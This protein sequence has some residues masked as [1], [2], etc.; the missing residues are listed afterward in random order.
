MLALP[1]SEQLKL[2]RRK[3]LHLLVRSV[4]ATAKDDSLNT[5]GFSTPFQKASYQSASKSWL[6]VPDTA[7]LTASV[8]EFL[9]K[10]KKKKNELLWVFVIYTTTAG[11]SIF[12]FHLTATDR[13]IMFST[14]TFGNNTHCTDMLQLRLE[15]VYN[16]YQ[17]ATREW[18]RLYMCQLTFLSQ[19]DRFLPKAFTEQDAEASP[20]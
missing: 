6:T 19:A 16:P 4:L 20:V 18:R 13:S 10:K 8:T 11:I 15:H 5:E 2:M 17:S 1:V 14:Q 7:R 9:K 12:T 3:F